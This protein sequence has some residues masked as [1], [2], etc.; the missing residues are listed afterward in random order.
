MTTPQTDAA[1]AAAERVLRVGRWMDAGLRVPGTRLQVGVDALLGLIPGLGDLAGLLLSLWLINEAYRAG[2]PRRLLIRMAGN[3][4]LDAGAGALPVVGDIF[5]FYFRANQRNAELLRQHFEPGTVA[6]TGRRL[7]PRLLA[8]L[9]C[10]TGMLLWW[11]LHS[12][13]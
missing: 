9:L 7:M 11:W 8:L 5:D 12:G 13:R 2:A 6:M 4:L 10:L 1:R 3:A